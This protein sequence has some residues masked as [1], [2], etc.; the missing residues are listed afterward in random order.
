M[1]IILTV[2]ALIAG[3]FLPLANTDWAEGMRTDAN[4]GENQED[5]GARVDM[6]AAFGWIMS[7]V[8]IAI[9]MV[10]P[11]LITLGIRRLVKGKPK[12]RSAAP[13]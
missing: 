7:F 8:K 3:L 4:T 6:P 10:I 13:A 2:S 1:I 5:G 11:G 12:S 9:F